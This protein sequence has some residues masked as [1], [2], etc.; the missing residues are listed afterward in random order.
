[1]NL[2]SFGIRAWPLA[3]LYLAVAVYVQKI[4]LTENFSTD[5]M[6]NQWRVFGESNLF[7]WDPANHNLRV[8]WDSSRT[9][10]YFYHL[11]GTIVTGDDDFALSFDLVFQDYKI[12]TTSGRAYT[13]PVAIGLLNL[14]NAT[15]T[16]FSRGSGINAA[17]GPKNL[18]EFD[19]FPAFDAFSPTIAQAIVST[20]NDWLYNHDNLLDMPAGDLFH[21]EMNYDGL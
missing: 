13:F 3:G 4:T 2:L 11:L 18:V 6:V 16:N 19:F 1:M 5:P 20:N 15:Q 17:Y 21:I 9:N 12:G 10:S 14:A 7:Q 8:T